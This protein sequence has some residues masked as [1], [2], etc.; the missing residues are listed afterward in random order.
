MKL[1][2]YLITSFIFLLS[3]FYGK[4]QQSDKSFLSAV[5]SSPTTYAQKISFHSKILNEDRK[6]NIYLPE[7][8]YTASEDHTYPV[9]LISGSHGNKF[10]LTISGVIE[11]LSYVNRM[12]EAIVISFEEETHY[13]PNVYTNGMW[14]SRETIEFNAD[15][16]KFIRH[17]KE[18]LFPYLKQQYRA[19]DYR[20]IVGVSGSSV[21]PLHTFA[22]A[23]DLFQAHITVASADMIGMGYNP[24]ET[25]IDAFEEV[26][27]NNPNRKAQFY[28]A[29]AEDDVKKNDTYLK[30][31]DKLK[32]KLTPFLSKSL[33]LKIEVIPDEGHYDCIIKAMLSSMEMIFPK[34]K[35]SLKF[36]EIIKEPGNALEN[37][38]AYH[39]NLSKIYGFPILPKA[40]RWNN[41]NCLRFIGGKL[42][43]DGR[44]KESIQ[45]FKR[46]V[47]YRPNSPWAYQSL[48]EALETNNQLKEALTAQEKALQLA[49][50]YNKDQ[51]TDYK[52]RIKKIQQKLGK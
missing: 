16:T 37:I 49:K 45:V 41:V 24:G 4:A 39:Q 46:R 20:I 44:I 9:I 36:R 14:S 1:H 51:I 8:F 40:E 27:I 22:Q 34:D 7:S 48:S 12:P 35:W 11:H 13:A 30:N 15:P 47:K 50:T 17:L 19:A 31:M 42:L 52:N 26:F 33:K 5:S 25:F 43:R 6:M 28:L 38:D 23:P 10:F 18:E 21:F 32:G 3:I 2:S 29:V